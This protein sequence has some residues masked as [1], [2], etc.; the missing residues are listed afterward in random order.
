[1]PEQ[2]PRLFA[3]DEEQT[4]VVVLR[5]RRRA[6]KDRRFR[7][8]HHSL[9]AQVPT[10]LSGTTLDQGANISGLRW[11]G[12]TSEWGDRMGVLAPSKVFGCGWNPD[13]AV[14]IRCVR[15]SSRRCGAGEVF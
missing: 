14:N 3:K 6:L 13:K 4:S 5:T 12:W 15:R 8:P 2:D 10:H 1:M 11:F 7:T 9:R